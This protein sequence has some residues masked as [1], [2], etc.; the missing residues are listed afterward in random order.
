LD[1]EMGRRMGKYLRSEKEGRIGERKKKSSF[2]QQRRSNKE[3]EETD[4]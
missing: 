3:G 4:T 2:Q 1:E